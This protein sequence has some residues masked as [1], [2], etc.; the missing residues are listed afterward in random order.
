MPTTSNRI[1]MARRSFLRGC[2]AVIALLPAGWSGVQVRR[3]RNG[4]LL[5]RDDR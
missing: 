1:G 2:A 3:H 5:R 4:W